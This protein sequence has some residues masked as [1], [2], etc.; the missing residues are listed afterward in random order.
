MWTSTIQDLRIN[1]VGPFE[2]TRRFVYELSWS[3]DG[4]NLHLCWSSGMMMSSSSRCIN[5]DDH[6][7]NSRLQS[8]KIYTE[9]VGLQDL[10][11]ESYLFDCESPIT[12][13]TLCG[14]TKRQTIGVNILVSFFALDVETEPSKK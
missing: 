8:D 10:L 6:L 2:M 13:G 12:H 4:F 3:S 14:A 9:N 1:G 7:V 5:L 11:S